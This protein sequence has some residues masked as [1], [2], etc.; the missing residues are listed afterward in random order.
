MAP[1]TQAAIAQTKADF[2]THFQRGDIATAAQVF[3]PDARSF[4][5]GF[6]QIDGQA[7]L[8]AFWAETT[9][10]LRITGVQLSTTLL[11]DHGDTIFEE[12]HYVFSQVEGVLD[13]GQY[14][15]AWQQQADG[16]WKWRRDIWNSNKT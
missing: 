11:E 14:L 16:A 10:K 6:P 15:I 8:T 3:T 4:P 1:A 9:V 5:P 13:K 2:L 12:G 7:A